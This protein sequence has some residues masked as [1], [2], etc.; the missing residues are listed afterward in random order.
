MIKFSIIVPIYNI[1]KYVEKCIESLINQTYK[2]IEILLID[3]GSTDSCPEICKKYEEKDNRIKYIRKENGGLS[4]ARNCGLSNANGDYIWFVDGD[5]YIKNDALEI[6]EKELIKNDYDVLCFNTYTGNEDGFKERNIQNSIETENIYQKYVISAPSACFKIFKHELLKKS[7]FKFREGIIYEDLAII[8]SL[9]CYTD[10]IGFI[11]D[12]LY[13]YVTRNDS[14]MHVKKFN[15]NREHKYIALENLEGI[16]K[17]NNLFDKY[18]NEIE[19][20]YIK[21]LIITYS[22]ELLIYDKK[23]YKERLK[24]AVKYMNEKFPNWTKNYYFNKEPFSKKIYV[25][26]IKNEVYFIPKLI[27][28]LYKVVHG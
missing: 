6:L 9:L 28:N 11:E 27:N 15:P 12:Y 5:D 26:A 22:T 23:I 25:Y 1:E 7:N 24:N 2:N 13:Y 10:K 20:L 8:P 4:S 14:I 19:Y 3:D 18:K 16:F 17:E 21:H